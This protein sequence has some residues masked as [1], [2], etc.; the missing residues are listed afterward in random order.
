MDVIVKS[1]KCLLTILR[2][3]IITY[4]LL[5]FFFKALYII[6]PAFQ[7]QQAVKILRLLGL[8]A[9]LSIVVK[10]MNLNKESNNL[11]YPY[12]AF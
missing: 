4:S 7:A 1:T 2:S 11:P 9:Y 5:L 12:Y 6:S 3:A 10:T 8:R